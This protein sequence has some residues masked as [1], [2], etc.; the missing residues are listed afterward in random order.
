M[1]HKL[2][3]E[4]I[5]SLRDAQR[6]ALQSHV[7]EESL[8]TCFVENE[9][10]HR[11]LVNHLILDNE[12]G[13]IPDSAALVIEDTQTEEVWRSILAILEEGDAIKI[14]WCRGTYTS[15]EMLPYNLAGDAVEVEIESEKHHLVF[16]LLLH[17]AAKD[18]SN[19][20]FRFGE[21]KNTQKKSKNHHAR[22][23]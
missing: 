5:Q 17:V 12:G 23:R 22:T 19:R 18:S 16:L 9:I 8:I 11:V 1:T 10:Y 14:R 6:V 2:T 4:D 13:D 20:I 7:G 3:A 21:E 15:P